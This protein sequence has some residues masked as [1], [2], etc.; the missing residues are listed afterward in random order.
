MADRTLAARIQELAAQF[1][2]AEEKV[3][4]RA[5]LRAG[6]AGRKTVKR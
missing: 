6:K 1:V 5:R 2:V 3:G 4:A